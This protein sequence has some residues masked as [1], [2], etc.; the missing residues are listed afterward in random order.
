[1]KL[2]FETL[3]KPYS[4]VTAVSS[5]SFGNAQGESQGYFQKSIYSM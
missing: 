3:G 2:F 1:M 4:G 5:T